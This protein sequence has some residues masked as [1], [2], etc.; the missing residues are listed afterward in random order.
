MDK[1]KVREHRDY[2]DYNTWF[3]MLMGLCRTGNNKDIV[4]YFKKSEEILSCRKLEEIQC[5]L[6]KTYI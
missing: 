1:V 2:N 4:L 6:G 5:Y 3:K